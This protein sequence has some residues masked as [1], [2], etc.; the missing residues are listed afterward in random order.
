LNQE[1]FWR[2]CKEPVD[3]DEA[4]EAL[5]RFIDHKGK[6]HIPARPNDDDMLLSRSLRELKELRE[7]I[8]YTSLPEMEFEIHFDED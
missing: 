2:K 6:L 3:I 1:E 4:H 7:K 8:K 5:K